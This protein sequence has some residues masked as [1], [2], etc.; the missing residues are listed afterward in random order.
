[1]Q[2]GH[3]DGIHVNP[4]SFVRSL[5]HFGIAENLRPGHENLRHLTVTSIY[6][7]CVYFWSSR[8]KTRGNICAISSFCFSAGR[9]AIYCC[10]KR[11]TIPISHSLIPDL[12]LKPWRRELESWAFL[13]PMFHQR[14]FR[15]RS[16]LVVI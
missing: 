4:P 9:T 5:R 6:I 8:V 16:S 14:R 15:F 1:M 2:W 3:G 13:R 10:R 12:V 7:N 11:L